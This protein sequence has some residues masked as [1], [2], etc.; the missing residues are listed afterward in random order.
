VQALVRA[1]GDPYKA[2]HIAQANPA[3]KDTPEVV[4]VLK[5]ASDAGTTTDTDWASKLVYYNDMASEFVDLLRPAM[6]LG[7]FGQGGIPGLRRVP[8][9]VRMAT[10]T[11]G[12]TY[13]WVGEGLAKPV[14]ELTIGE[15]TLRW[16]KASGIIVISDELAR[17]S[18]P[19]A[20]SVV[21]QDMVAGMA[22]FLDN[23]FVNP[24]VGEVSNISPASVFNGVTPVTATGTTADAL[25]DDIASLLESFFTANHTPTTGVFI[26]SNRQALRIG[27]MRNA[28]GQKE[29]GD[30]TALGGTLEG[31]PVIASENVPDDS[32]G[33]MIGFVNASDIFLTDDG[34][35]TID[36]SREASLQMNTTPDEPTSASTV[37]VSLWQR[38]LIGLRAERYINWKKRRSTAAAFIQGANYG[39]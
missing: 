27:M 9:N 28:L 3:W 8:A 2:H 33:G 22:A 34:P 29:F 37:L 15:I 17:E 6:I 10:Q 20:E 21:R 7:K 18:S 13:R 19:S 30:L 31:F 36:A 4:M 12:G 23:Q 25:R 38:N 35:V 1:S 14:G 16:A 11:G 5:A 39:S 24:D 26:M 32:N